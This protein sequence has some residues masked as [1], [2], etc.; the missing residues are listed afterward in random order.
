MGFAYCKLGD[1][2]EFLMI[3]RI[4]SLLVLSIVLLMGCKREPISWDNRIAAP[5]FSTQLRLG[6][7][8]NA[9]F[10]PN[11]VDSSYRLVYENLVYS[12]R[13]E[14][15]RA[16]DTGLS[17]FFTLNRLKLND[18]KI[19]RSITLG[20]I[21]PIFKLLDGQT[22]IV[23]AQNQ[24]NLSPVQIDASAFFETATLDSGYMDISL[25]NSLPVRVKLLVFELLNADDNSVVAL[26]SFRDIDTGTT[27]TRR[28]DLANKTVTKNLLGSIKLLQTEA[29]NGPVLI[30][31]NKG[32]NV[33]LAVTRLRPRRAIAAFPSQTVIS[34]DEGLTVYMG[35]SEV[36]YFKAKRGRIR[37]NL[38]STIEEDMT[39]FFKIPSASKDGKVLETI[40]KLP[41]AAKGAVSTRYEDFDL[42]DYMIDFRGKNPDVKDT[43]NT[44]HQILLVT[45]DSSGRKVEVGLSDSIRIEYRMEG[46]Y[47][48]YAIGYLGNSLNQTGLQKAPFDLFKGVNSD[49]RLKDFKVSLI[50]KNSIGADGRIRLNSLAGENVFT[51]KT[52]SLKSEVLG[53]DLLVTSPPF[54]RDAYTQTEVILDSTNSNIRTF[55]EN[56]PQQLQ[57]DLD[58]ETSPNGNV[59]N[60]GDFV[61]DNSKVDVILKIE[62]PAQLS[63][64]ELVLRDTQSLDLRSLGDLSRVKSA[65][66][67]I[68]ANNGFPYGAKVG[69]SLLDNAMNVLENLDVTTESGQIEPG[70]VLP[71]GTPVETVEST[72]EIAL[73]RKKIGS[74]QQAKF[75]AIEATLFSDGIMKKLNSAYGL[76]IATA[77]DCEYEVRVGGK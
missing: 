41:G 26:D 67:E 70:I 35:G 11:L 28:I 20:E 44:F 54:K 56:L 10:Q 34:Q 60:W 39:M 62:A 31:A 33:E 30:Q 58:L 59:N 50:L 21:N 68:K 4:Y 46:M 19:N 61:F 5:L 22:A 7:I 65:V 37:I 16:Y 76:Q 27:A 2:S 77:L 15:V 74:L 3:K 36:K 73:P 17:V 18:Q 66:M 14:N 40:I 53:Q 45:L 12:Y 72:L 55:I 47:P 64:S 48:D 71:D 75:V 43:V 52:E 1:I 23:P 24:Q 25:T 51:T 6:N 57:Y 32:V 49:L 42:T 38:V 13:M 8:N 29:S 69:I 63:F 9:N